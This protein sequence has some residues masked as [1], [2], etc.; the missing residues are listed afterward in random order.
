MMSHNIMPRRAARMAHFG[1]VAAGLCMTPASAQGLFGPGKFKIEQVDDRFSIEPTI[2]IMGRNNRIS[3][4]SPVGGIYTNAQGLYLEPLVIKSRADG[5]VVK[6]GFLFHNEA[7]LD[8]TYGSPNSLGIPRTVSFLLNDSR[9]IAAPVTQGTKEFGEGMFYNSIS[10]SASS[11]VRENGMVL[12]SS[13]DMAAIASATSV[14]IKIE[15]STRSVIYESRDI[16]K[17]FL[18]NIASFYGREIGG[19][20]SGY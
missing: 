18:P 4:K 9:L 8:T 2:M 10:N 7:T 14:S 17:T 11:S 5:T 20:K 13:G 16:A 12:L 1:F 19:Q 3:K 6:I 15:G